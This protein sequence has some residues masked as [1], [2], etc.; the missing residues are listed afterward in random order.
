MA[1]SYDKV[2]ELMQAFHQKGKSP[3]GVSALV[4]MLGNLD[5]KTE[6]HILKTLQKQNPKLA[7]EVKEAYFTFEDLLELED[8]VLKKALQEVHRT[9]LTVALKGTSEDIQ[10]KVFR[11]LSQRAARNVKE[12]M[13]FMGPKP[14]SLIEEAQKEVT[15]VLRRWK[16]V[17][18]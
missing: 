7:E 18:L 3:G 4:Q 15:K 16:N 2:K 17:I 14:I 8:A 13:E 1:D 5:R 12:D 9:T 11:N 10:E 6:K